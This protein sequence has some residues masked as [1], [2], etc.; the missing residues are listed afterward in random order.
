MRNSAVCCVLLAVAV[1][2]PTPALADCPNFSFVCPGAKPAG[3]Q[4]VEA[5]ARQG[6]AGILSMVGATLFTV[7]TCWNWSHA[8]CETCVPVVDRALQKCAN[9]CGAQWRSRADGCSI[10]VEGL[11]QIWNEVF[12]ASCDLHDLCYAS[13]GHSQADCDRWFLANMKATC[14]F[15]G[16]ATFGVGKTNC[17]ASAEI[18]HAA[19]QA[20]GKSS[21]D[22]G[23]GW[24]QNNCS[25]P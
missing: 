3:A 25:A 1:L 20:K 5:A 23:Q 17:L 10:P 4:D 11:K 16:L 15:P 24:A 22:N 2:C 14:T 18:I 21:F 7:N 9:P 12:H 19:V 8:Q 13:L 6:L